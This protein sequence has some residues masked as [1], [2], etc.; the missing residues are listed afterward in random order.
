MAVFGG[1][2]GYPA[3]VWITFSYFF[4][5]DIEGRELEENEENVSNI[6]ASIQVL[7][8][9]IFNDGGC[10]SVSLSLLYYL[11]MVVVVQI[12]LF[13]SLSLPHTL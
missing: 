6:A 10:L 3:A 8:W 9:Y 2:I 13:L 12:N 1:S 11:N 5:G 4:R 7:F